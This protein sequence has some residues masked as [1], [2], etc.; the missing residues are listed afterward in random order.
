MADENSSCINQ[1]RK[2]SD[3]DG[4]NTKNIL[5]AVTGS[6]ASV[7]LPIIVKSLLEAEPKVSFVCSTKSQS[8]L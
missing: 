7:K 3:K 2:I 1:K 6:V 4:P 5:V 8:W